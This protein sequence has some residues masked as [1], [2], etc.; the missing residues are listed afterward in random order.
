MIAICQCYKI[1]H[2]IQQSQLEHQSVNQQFHDRRRKLA[3][4][5]RI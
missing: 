1:V 2:E 5:W 4:R 3:T